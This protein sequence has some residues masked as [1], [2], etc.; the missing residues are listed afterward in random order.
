E[1]DHD[2]MN[3]TLDLAIDLNC[4]FAN[5]YSAMAYP[6]SPLYTMAVQQGVP[7]PE[8]WTGYSQHSGDC[9]P[10][11]TKYIT[12][13]DVLQFRDEAFVKY[14]TNTSYLE[15]VWR[16]FGS[17]TASHIREMTSHRLER[18]LISG[19]LNVPLETLPKKEAEPAPHLLQ[20]RVPA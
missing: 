20:L 9:Q 14:Y 3:A 15:M 7:L 10:L 5:F 4:E 17:E 19:K 2:T 16:K 12:A 1:D 13:R 11:P 8:Q 6:G 18:D